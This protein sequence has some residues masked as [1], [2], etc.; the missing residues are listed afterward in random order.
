MRKV[1]ILAIL[2]IMWVCQGCALQVLADPADPKW[3]SWQVND[4]MQAQSDLTLVAVILA[5]L[6]VG[7]LLM[8]MWTRR[9]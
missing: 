6:C 9:K 2:G 7:G 4:A 8:W 5:I 3:N 1:G